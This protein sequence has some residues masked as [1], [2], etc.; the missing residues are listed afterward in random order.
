M[1]DITIREETRDDTHAIDVV[2]RSAFGGD[3]ET[4]LVRDLRAS[5]GYVPE[6]SLV[7][8][9]NGRISGHIVLF[10]ARLDR[11]DGHADILALAPMSVVPSQSHRGIGSM[12][13]RAALTK[14]TSLGYGGIIVVGHP[15]YY[16]K[17]GFEKAAKWN[18]RCP[19]PVPED[20]VTA[21]E[22]VAGALSG[23]GVLNYPVEFKRFFKAA[24]GAQD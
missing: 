22:L 1:G 14:A 7:A 13:V 15:E 19:L 6:L 20:V 3:A 24:G 17:F 23:G 4:K 8:E 2:N 16:T 12:L 18:I 21:K 11:Q 5:K 10:R 9:I